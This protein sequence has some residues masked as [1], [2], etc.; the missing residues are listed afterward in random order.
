MVMAKI[1]I[2]D[3]EEVTYKGNLILITVENKEKAQMIFDEW[4]KQRA[5]SKIGEAKPILKKI[6]EYFKAPNH[7]YF[8][9]MPTRWGSCTIKNKLTFNPKLIHTT[10]RCIEYVTM[11]ELCHT[12][13]K[14][15]NQDF[16]D[17]LT[18]MK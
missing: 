1:I 2:A 16:F 10:K 3:K 5:Y 14:H 7:I 13:H 4:L 18:L 12:I 8:Q 9:D 15:H 6:S 11:H 17:L